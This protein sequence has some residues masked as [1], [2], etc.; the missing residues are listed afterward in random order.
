MK[1]KYKQVLVYD[2]ISNQELQKYCKEYNLVTVS[3]LKDQL[4]YIFERKNLFSR[5][6]NKLF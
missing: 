6:I 5:I 1:P 4:L 3:K 2:M